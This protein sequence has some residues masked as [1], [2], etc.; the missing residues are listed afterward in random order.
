MK[1]NMLKTLLF[2][3]LGVIMAIVFTS[4]KLYVSPPGV[5]G[6]PIVI[7]MQRDKCTIKYTAPADDGGAPIIGYGIEMKY[8][9]NA[10]WILI[11]QT[12]IKEL[13]YTVTNLKEGEEV[14]FRVYALNIAGRGSSSAPC[15]PILVRDHH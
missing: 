13:E 14:Q 7:D 8:T 3:S 1:K 15:S 6:I 9:K 2:A 10:E 4:A 5:P 12:P 11:N